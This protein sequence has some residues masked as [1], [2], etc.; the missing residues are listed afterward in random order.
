MAKKKTNNRFAVIDFE[1]ANGYRETVCSV[2]VVIVED[3]KIVDKFYSLINPQTKYFEKHCVAAHG[4]RYNDVKNSPK[5]SEVWEKVDKMIGNSPIVAHN[6]AFEKSCI[7]ACSRA[8]DTNNDYQYI[9]TLKLSRKYNKHLDSH[10]LNIL[11]EDIGY[12]LKNYH[13]ALAD[14]E[15]CAMVFINFIKNNKVID[16]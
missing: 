5:F 8:F 1:T 9:D 3:C 16:I 12:D 7:N 4:L 15:A 13:N 14:A 2:G 6:A 11:C 10:K